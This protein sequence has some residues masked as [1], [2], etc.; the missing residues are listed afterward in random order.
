MRRAFASVT[1]AAALAWAGAAW[2]VASVMTIVAL[3]GP[4][5][6]AAT[7]ILPGWKHSCGRN[8]RCFERGEA[9]RQARG[10]SMRLRY[11]PRLP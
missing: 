4:E 11:D 6:G 8:P 7:A 9:R 5:A 1:M 10:L 2:P 3:T